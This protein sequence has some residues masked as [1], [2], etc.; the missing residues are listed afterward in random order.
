MRFHVSIFID[1][2]L[3][4]VDSYLAGILSCAE[5]GRDLSGEEVRQVLEEEKA[6]GH[7]YFCGCDNRKADGTCAGHRIDE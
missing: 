4:K 7:S 5:T 2:M 6:L 3:N 1:G